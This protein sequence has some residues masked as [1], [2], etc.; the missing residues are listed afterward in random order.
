MYLTIIHS[1]Q[2]CIYLARTLIKKKIQGSI[3]NIGKKIILMKFGFTNP[4][5]KLISVNMIF[6]STKSYLFYEK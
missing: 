3:Y 2:S 6:D 4:L 5:Q 1:I